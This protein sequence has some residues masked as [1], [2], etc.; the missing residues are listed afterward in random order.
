M[1]KWHNT[2]DGWKLRRGDHDLYALPLVSGA[3]CAVVITRGLKMHESEHPTDRA[4]MAAAEARA[5]GPYEVRHLEAD[6][7]VDLARFRVPMVEGN[8]LRPGDT[9]LLL[10]QSDPAEN[11]VYIIGEHDCF[12]VAP[13]TRVTDFKLVSG[14]GYRATVTL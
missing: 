10:C 12:G 4:A 3:H 13:L 5:F 14:P 2:G 7:P 1:N 8:R 6:G 11:G 9:L